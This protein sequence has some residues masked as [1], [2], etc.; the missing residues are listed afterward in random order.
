M[1]ERNYSHNTIS[2]R[3]KIQ[4]QFHPYCGEE[5]E[6]ESKPRTHTGTFTVIDRE[7]KRLKVP[8]WMTKKESA[9]YHIEKIASIDI[10]SML[11]LQSFIDIHFKNSNP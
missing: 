11:R 10:D 9:Q 2:F 7:G 1:G 3:I 8:C 4:Y 5:L 6:I